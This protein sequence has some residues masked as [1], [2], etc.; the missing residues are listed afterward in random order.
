MSSWCHWN[1]PGRLERNCQQKWRVNRLNHKNLRFTRQRL[2]F[3]NERGGFVCRHCVFIFTKYD[4]N[5]ILA[6][7][8]SRNWCDEQQKWRST[9]ETSDKWGLAGSGTLGWQ[10]F[11][12]GSQHQEKELVGGA[13]TIL[14][15]MSSSMG[16]MTSHIWNGSHKSI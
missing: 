9:N 3:N 7:K 11:W 14:K 4:K 15:I 13:I 5:V 12:K 8:I 16:R 2:G 6:A 1:F 10:S